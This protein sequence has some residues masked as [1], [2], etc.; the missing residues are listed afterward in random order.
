MVTENFFK[1]TYNKFDDYILTQLT[2]Y[3]K[4]K[5]S[6]KLRYVLAIL[7]SLPTYFIATICLIASGIEKNKLINE[8]CK[9]R[10]NY[11]DAEE[12]AEKLECLDELIFGLGKNCRLWEIY[13]TT[14]AANAKYNYGSEYNYYRTVAPFRFDNKK[15]E[16]ISTDVNIPY[17]YVSGRDIYFLPDKV[18][19]IKKKKIQIKDY[20]SINVI[21][22]KIKRHELENVPK[23]AK[24]IGQ[25][26]QYSN[27]DGT[28][29]MRFVD[30][31]SCPLC[32]YGQV[33]IDFDGFVI[34]LNVSNSEQ[35]K[36]IN[37]AFKKL[38]A[39]NKKIEESNP[40]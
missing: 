11:K 21:C 27:M 19:I 33:V 23:D 31:C 24:V 25:A 10:I 28:R 6:V 14:P 12:N 8:T 40:L 4:G 22:R 13:K 15:L 32:Y 34:E 26:W 35:I 2:E 17:L 38:K 20:E 3:K 18:I 9:V 1:T 39:C 29:D 7:L 36:Y 16:N 5:S 30:N 37:S